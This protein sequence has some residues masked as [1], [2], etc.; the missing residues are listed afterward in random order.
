MEDAHIANPNF[1]KTCSLFAVFDGHGGAE[2]S[3]FAKKFFEAELLKNTNF[4][5]KKYEAALTETFEA[6]DKLLL[7]KTGEKEIAQI[8]KMLAEKEKDKEK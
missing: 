6:M 1:T 4:A 5:N 3:N 7:S 2:V 8:K